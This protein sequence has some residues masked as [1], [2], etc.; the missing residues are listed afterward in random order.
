MMLTVETERTKH[1]ATDPLTR[2][3]E[4]AAETLE[5]YHESWDAL[6]QWRGEVELD[7]K[8]IIAVVGQK[9]WERVAA[10]FFTKVKLRPHAKRMRDAQIV[11]AQVYAERAFEKPAEPTRKLRNTAIKVELGI[12]GQVTIDGKEL[13]YCT[14]AEVLA[15][16]KRSTSRA[17]FLA[18]I[19]ELLPTDDAVVK[20]FVTPTAAKKISAVA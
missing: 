6:E 3:R 17:T 14:K 15:E 12:L 11:N 13:A 19:A 10:D 18:A 4:M 5:A 8:L 9:N 7:P 20:D 2:A 1:N 16:Q